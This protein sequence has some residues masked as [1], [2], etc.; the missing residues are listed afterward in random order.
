MRGMPDVE[1]QL[2]GHRQFWIELKVAARPT[3]PE[4]PVHFKVRPEQV[5]WLNHRYKAGGNAWLLIMVGSGYNRA[6]YLV[7][8]FNAAELKQGVTEERLKELNVLEPNPK[9]SDVVR[10][11]AER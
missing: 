2:T 1:G 6:L 3:K 10:R 11:A 7:R 5:E 8:G 9:A 4:T